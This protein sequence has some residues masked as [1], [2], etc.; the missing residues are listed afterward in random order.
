MKNYLDLF[1]GIGG[2]A[3]GAQWA[4][5]KFDNHYFSEVDS[6]AINVYKK[7]F[8]EAVELGDIKRIDYSTL[9]EEIMGGLSKIKAERYLEKT[10]HTK[11]HQIQKK[12]VKME[13]APIFVSGGFP[14][15]ANPTPALGKEERQRTSVIYGLNVGECFANFDR[16]SHSL[17]TLQGYLL[18]NMGD[19]LSE[20]SG[21]FPNAGMMRNGKLYRLQTSARRI[22][23]K[24]C[25][26]LP[27]PKAS[28]GAWYKRIKLRHVKK[29][30]GKNIRNGNMYGL[31]L[32]EII[33]LNFGKAMNLSFA[34]WMMG[35]P[36]GWT[37]LNVAETR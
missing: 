2:F 27:T 6:Y 20:S 30:A 15:R 28:D 16:N 5:L 34:E 7:R 10:E 32:P 37:D 26:L 31:R 4:G 8:P 29:V 36:I 23:E 19:F 14:D 13:A 21:T 22:C 25:G 35:Y 24:G 9:R 11:L 18:P 3:L 1:S 33:L 12:E 17:K